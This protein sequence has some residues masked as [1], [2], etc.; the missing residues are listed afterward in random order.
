MGLGREVIVDRFFLRLLDGATVS[1]C[2][3]PYYIS[4]LLGEG[5]LPGVQSYTAGEQSDGIWSHSPLIGVSSEARVGEWGLTCL[6]N[7]RKDMVQ[8]IAAEG[9]QTK[10]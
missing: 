3:S 9:E 1:L 2:H 8:S 4:R 6:S 5:S 10:E 7:D